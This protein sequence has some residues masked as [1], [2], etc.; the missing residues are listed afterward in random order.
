MA[1]T[2]AHNSARN[3]FSESFLLHKK[4]DIQPLVDMKYSKSHVQVMMSAWQQGVLY[5]TENTCCTEFNQGSLGFLLPDG[6]QVAPLLVHPSEEVRKNANEVI[7]LG[8][9]MSKK[10][11]EATTKL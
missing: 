9:N 2:A 7:L 10:V 5:I 3:D 8:E 4:M 1:E 11:Q 6:V